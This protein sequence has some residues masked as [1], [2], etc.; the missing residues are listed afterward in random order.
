MSDKCFNCLTYY[1]YSKSS[2]EW[3]ACVCVNVYEVTLLTAL[4]GSILGLSMA[5]VMQL[6]K[7]MTRTTWSN[8][9]WEMILLQV[10]RNLQD[11]ITPDMVGWVMQTFNI[12]LINKKLISTKTMS[13]SLTSFCATTVI[14]LFLME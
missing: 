4:E 14:E 10:T 13:Q 7:M 2:F 11:I 1:S 6:R 3:H 5:I 8:I 9:L 12:K